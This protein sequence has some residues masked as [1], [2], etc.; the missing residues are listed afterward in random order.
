MCLSV[1][2]CVH[3]YRCGEHA[4][5]TLLAAGNA[6][7]SPIIRVAQIQYGGEAGSMSEL[8]RMSLF[9]ENSVFLR[10]GNFDAPADASA[11]Q[12]ASDLGLKCVVGCHSLTHSRA[13]AMLLAR[14]VDFSTTPIT[15]NRTPADVHVRRVR[16]AAGD[17]DGDVVIA[18]MVVVVVVITTIACDEYVFVCFVFACVR[19]C[20][21][22]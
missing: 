17:D 7:Q 5:T 4:F 18:T 9:T 10:A 8:S 3:A 12:L 19:A 11:C 2:V 21:R 13:A 16:F 1:S 15:H 6:T 14:M 20:V 22:A